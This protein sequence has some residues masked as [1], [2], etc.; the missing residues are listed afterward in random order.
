MIAGSWL[1]QEF[2]I[3]QQTIV[4]LSAPFLTLAV[5]LAGQKWFEIFV[6][7]Q[8]SNQAHFARSPLDGVAE[9]KNIEI[10]EKGMGKL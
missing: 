2:F 4:P 6:R 7:I 10:K 1:I 8:N 5:L 3:S 9:E